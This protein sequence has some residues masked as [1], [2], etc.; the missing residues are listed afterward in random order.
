MRLDTSAENSL[1]SQPSSMP[2]TTLEN[3]TARLYLQ[4]AAQAADE[5]WQPAVQGH[6]GPTITSPTILEIEQSGSHLIARQRKRLRTTFTTLRNSRLSAP[7]LQAQLARLFD[8]TRLRRL[9]NTLRTQGAWQQVTRIE[10]VCHTQVSHEWFYHLHAGAGRVL[11]PYDYI[12]NVQ[13][14]LGYTGFGQCRHWIILGLSIHAVL[15]RL[16]LAV[17]GITR[18]RRG[19]TET[20]SRPADLFTTAAVPGRSAAQDASFGL[21]QCSSGSRRRSA[22]GV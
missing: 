21:L 3:P 1:A 17:P 22:G 5:S 7:Q 12:T 11:T 6:N 16:R 14:K 19:L 10:D 4:K 8:R 15:G 9:E 13:K 18:E 20:Q 2:L